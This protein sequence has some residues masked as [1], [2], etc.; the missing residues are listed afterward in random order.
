MAPAR[1]SGKGGLT[2]TLK[3]SPEKL[4][5]LFS[6]EQEKVDSPMKDAASNKDITEAK[7]GQDTQTPEANGSPAPASSQPA[8]VQAVNGETISDSN[9]STP[10]P[11]AMGPPG[12]KG[13]KR[14]AATNGEPKS[15]GKPGPKKKAKLYVILILLSPKAREHALTF[16]LL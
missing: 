2:V 5:E 11:S 15:R 14:S 8:A 13:T 12:K 16:T 6:D 4:R 10:G 9:P 1:K 7:D 3:V